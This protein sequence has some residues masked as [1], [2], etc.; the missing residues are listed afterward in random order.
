MESVSE[1]EWTGER[2]T[3]HLNEMN[4]TQILKLPDLGLRVIRK[5][6]SGIFELEYRA[7]NF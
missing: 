7:V 2:M 5:L 4:P 1:A 6:A 3:I